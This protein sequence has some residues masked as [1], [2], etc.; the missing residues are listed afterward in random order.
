MKD[1]NDRTPRTVPFKLLAKLED[2]RATPE[3]IARAAHED[4]TVL[5]RVVNAV[6]RHPWLMGKG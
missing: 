4:P 6:E 3:Q 2:L 5:R 1:A